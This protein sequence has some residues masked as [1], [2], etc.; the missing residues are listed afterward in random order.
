MRGNLDP[1]LG[2]WIFIYNKYNPFIYC[3]DLSSL[4]II[5]HTLSISDMLASS[6][7][8]IS[9]LL[10][11][12]PVL[13]CLSLNHLANNC[14]DIN[15]QVVELACIVKSI[16]MVSKTVYIAPKYVKQTWLVLR[17][18]KRKITQLTFQWLV[19]ERWQKCAPW[20]SRTDCHRPCCS[21][22][23]VWTWTLPF[24]YCTANHVVSWEKNDFTI[25]FSWYAL[26]SGLPLQTCIEVRAWTALER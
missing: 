1:P 16:H 21:F 20:N 25:F 23:D 4:S 17:I 18:G 8:L 6:F 9:P 22:S 7:S 15:C 3:H 24:E 13:F 14:K 19:I 11:L 5:H 26:K 12:L 2:I 10:G